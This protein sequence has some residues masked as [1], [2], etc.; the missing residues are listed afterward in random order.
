MGNGESC[1]IKLLGVKVILVK[2]VTMYITTNKYKQD[3]TTNV[4]KVKINSKYKRNRIA[5]D[6]GK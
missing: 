2:F 4:V 3:A 1:H 6:R 5:G